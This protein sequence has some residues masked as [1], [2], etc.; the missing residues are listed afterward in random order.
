M[1]S[2]LKIGNL[3]MTPQEVFLACLGANS[4]AS[5]WILKGGAGVGQRIFAGH[6]YDAQAAL[7][8]MGSW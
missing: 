8:Y 6:E 1:L 4:D 2:L 3:Y 5:T 7:T